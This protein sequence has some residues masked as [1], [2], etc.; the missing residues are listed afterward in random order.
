VQH[1]P[2]TYEELEPYYTKVDWEIGVSGQQGPWDPP[3]SQDYPC[4]AMPLKS[5]D[6]LLERGAGKSE[7]LAKQHMR[8]APRLGFNVDHGKGGRTKWQ[9]QQ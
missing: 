6:V 2:I 9:Q 4:P 7:S 3:H 8:I 5:S 1:W